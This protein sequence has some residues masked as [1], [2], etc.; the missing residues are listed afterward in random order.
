[1]TLSS[2]SLS[3]ARAQI[4][5][6]EYLLDP[7]IAALATQAAVKSRTAGAHNPG[8]AQITPEAV[9]LT[10]VMTSNEM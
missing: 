6:E 7:M 4:H 8:A 1:M 5:A 3:R 2:S 10:A 9:L